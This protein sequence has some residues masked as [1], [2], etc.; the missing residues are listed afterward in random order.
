MAYYRASGGSEKVASGTVATSSSS[1]TTITL[2]FK[3]KYIATVLG[4]ASNATMNIYNEDLSSTTA[5]YAGSSTYSSRYTIGNT[6]P[7]RITQITDTG[8]V[9]GT[10]NGSDLYYFAVG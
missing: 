1:S 5:K 4:T 2:G 10:S 3:P 6:T 7:Y 9:M 8:F